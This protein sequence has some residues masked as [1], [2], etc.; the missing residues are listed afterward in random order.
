[1]AGLV[2]AFTLP[3]FSLAAE[4]TLSIGIF[5]GTGTAD[6]LRADFRPMATPF[7]EELAKAVG[8]KVQLTMYRSLKSTNR[9]M[10]KGRKDLYFAPPT[11]AVA[12]FNKGYSPIARVEDFIKVVLVRR[13][14][15]TVTTVAL[16]EKQSVPDVL[17]RFVIKQ[18]NEKVRVIN[19]KTQEDVILAMK[20]N[21]A[22]AGGLGGKKAKALLEASDD[23]EVWYPL[24]QSPGFTL[25]AS[26]Q[27]S[28][29]DRS[30][31]EQAITSMDPKVVEKMQKAFVSKLG[32]F[33]A[34]KDAEFKILHQA[35]DEAGY[36]KGQ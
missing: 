30:K 18:N 16:T 3:S 36:L 27:L 2:L 25:V 8:R 19:L 13:K 1:M 10:V 24:P 32:T 34:D 22:Q 12:A 21:Y 7:A 20:R 11:V 9:S 26:N 17:G 31:L 29:S 28:E 35:M 23:Y 6:M 15:A 4:P 14:G 5:P 33:I